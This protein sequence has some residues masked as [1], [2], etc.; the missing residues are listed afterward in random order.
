MI[1]AIRVCSAPILVTVALLGGGREL[2]ASTAA[3]PLEQETSS[4]IDTALG[5]II[6][7]FMRS[8]IQS[9]QEERSERLQHFLTLRDDAERS[10]GSLDFRLSSPR[11]ELQLR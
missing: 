10:V 4:E 11:H 2:N 6:D 3:P 9:L 1:T 5:E 7:D 8:R